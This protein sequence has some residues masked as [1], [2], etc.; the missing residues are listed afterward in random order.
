MGRPTTAAQVCLLGLLLAPIAGRAAAQPLP[1]G[2]QALRVFL[3][4]GR[5]D[6]DYLR[7]EITFVNYVRDRRDADVHV[8]VTR[9][10]TGG[11]GD[12][13]TLDFYGL[14]P[15]AGMSDQLQFFTTQDDTDD[16]ERRILA[17]TLRLGLVRYAARTPLGQQLEVT[18]TPGGALGP[19][20][21]APAQPEDDPWNFW[22]FRARFNV[23][24]EAEERE[25]T[26]D[27]NTSFSANRTTE[28]WKM[29]V[30][31]NVNYQEDT[32][33]LTD[34][35]FTNVRRN[36]ALDAR[37]IKSLG[38]HMGVG[39][40][41]SAI[42]STFRN[43]DLTVRAAPALQYNFFPYSQSTRRQFTI[44]YSA[45]YTSFH[46]DEPTIFDRLEEDRLSHAIQ[47]S[48]EANEPWGDSDVTLEFSQF[49]DEP[50]RNRLVFF[51]DLEVRL[52]RGFFLNLNGSS[53]LIRDQIYLPRRD[54]TDEEILVRQ[55]QLATDFEWRV[56]I[57]FTYSFGSIF[58]NVVNS[59]FAGSSG[60]F[61]RAF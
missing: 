40:G 42:S 54:A 45:G 13:W 25:D 50:D 30:G 19:Q 53:S 31:V 7:R 1:N 37:F 27:F 55:R 58:N 4:C 52:F 41:G 38:E 15:F 22:V 57:G 34:S 49:L 60:G 32:F 2:A 11:G 56:R 16:D 14:G 59:R 17:R 35:T 51:G 12:A 24:L 43:Q 48:F 33:E 29:S 39:F 47:T 5:C 36:N 26:R 8:L 61:T 20:R 21:L 10:S 23:R 18:G 44:T 9:E 46:Y 3:D 6:D 28:A